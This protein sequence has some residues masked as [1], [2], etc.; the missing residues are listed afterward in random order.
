MNRQGT[1]PGK[2]FEKYCAR[3][4]EKIPVLRY[5]KNMASAIP[6]EKQEYFTYGDYL[7]WDDGRRWEIIDGIAFDMSPAPGRKH[8]KILGKL[9]WQLENFF[10]DKECDVYI[11]PFDVRLPL[12]NES[13][14]EIKNV[15]Q[16]D[17]VIVCDKT[18]LDDKGCLGAPDVA[19]EILSPSTATKDVEYKFQ[20]YQLHGVK[21]YWI[22]DQANSFLMRFSLG[23]DKKYGPPT[24]FAKDKILTSS[25]FPG[26]EVDLNVVFRD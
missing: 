26:L 6:K 11:A 7:Q 24:F 21:E 22:I 3:T 14:E 10:N 1:P 13:E 5:Y 15:V 25:L 2:Y 12:F 20:L 18:K 17:I 8:Q 23:E 4:V 9:N 16:P 19:V